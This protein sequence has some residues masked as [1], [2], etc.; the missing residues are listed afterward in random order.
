MLGYQTGTTWVCGGL[1][2]GT[3]AFGSPQLGGNGVGPEKADV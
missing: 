3:G 1:V 2:D